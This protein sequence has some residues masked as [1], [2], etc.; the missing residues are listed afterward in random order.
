MTRFFLA[1]VL[2][3]AF[4]FFA[5]SQTPQGIPYQAIARNS[6]GSIVAAVPI[7]LR[8]SIH[9][10]IANGPIKYRET[11][12]VTTSS[13]GLFNVNIGQGT[14]VLGSFTSI[15]WGQNAKFMQ[16]EMDPSGGNN[17][18]D[19][20]T[21]QM[22]SVPYSIYSAN[23]LPN[24]HLGDMLYHNGS[25]WVKLLAGK[26]GQ[27]L[28]MN[29]A[30]IPI[31]DGGSTLTVGSNYGG[32]VLAY[33]FHPGDAGYVVGEVHGLIAS[34]I[35][36]GLSQWGCWGTSTGGNGT[37]IGTGAANTLAILSSCND[38]TCAAYLCHAYRGGG[39]SDWYLPSQ[40][41]LNW[42]FINRVAIGANYWAY[43]SSTEAS[44]NVAWV[45]YFS[46]GTYSNDKYNTLNVRAIRSF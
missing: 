38:T 36:L 22:M 10:S 26:T 30:G 45:Q 6:N 40:D 43:W 42:I 21:T 13:L 2:F 11:F 31:W 35:D 33:I 12:S 28:T 25:N 39:F 37:A 9:D 46:G 16:V 3:S 27:V 29:N 17:Y 23:G 1:I 5:F 7:S 44:A 41:E 8:F 32:G 20:G 14:P 24:G 19:L 34:S 18:L 4:N 15:N